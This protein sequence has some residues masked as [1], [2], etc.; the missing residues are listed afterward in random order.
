MSP[1]RR[2]PSRWS[3]G[4]CRRTPSWP[5]ARWLSWCA[6]CQ[7]SGRAGARKPCA[8]RWS[9]RPS[10]SR[11][12]PG[13]GWRRLVNDSSPERDTESDRREARLL[14]LAFAFLALSAAGLALSP[15]VRSGAWPDAVTR[16]QGLLVLPGW[17]ALAWVLHRTLRAR[18]PGRDPLL[19]PVGVLL[20]GWGA[21]I[22]WRL[23]PDFGAR[24]TGWLLVGGV[25]CIEIVRGPADLGWLRRYR[26][27]WLV[28]G[29]G[30][31]GAAPA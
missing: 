19:L 15:V 8:P 28:G 17:G 11:P 6:A 3:C 26:Y 18:S 24:Q 25:G 1:K 10:A 23:A 9:H 13:S 31:V 29:P 22:V 12:G 20:A 14:G 21:L 16:W 5:S 27:L 30:L 2:S 4:G 7:R